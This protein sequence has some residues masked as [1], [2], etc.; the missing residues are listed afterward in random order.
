ML[1]RV[2]AESG[3][4][5]FEDLRSRMRSRDEKVMLS[6]LVFLTLR[7]ARRE[8]ATEVPCRERGVG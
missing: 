3:S 7:S 4:E 5:G 1:A 2:E 8:G 6:L